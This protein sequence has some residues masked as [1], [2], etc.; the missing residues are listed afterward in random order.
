VNSS[1]TISH[2]S[3]KI[4]RSIILPGSKSESN[5]TLII[6]KLSGNKIY[7]NNL[8]VADDTQILIRLLSDK[9]KK[10]DVKDAGTDMRFLIAC[11]C[12]LNK[13]K[14]ITGSPR[15]QERPVEKLIDALHDI[16][17]K[18]QYLKNR[19]FPPVEIIPVENLHLTNE[20]S[21]DAGESS[22]FISALLM[23]APLLPEGL[24]IKLKN[25][26]VSKPYIEMTLQMM[27]LCGVNYEWKKNII[28]IKKQAYRK[29]EL[30]IETDWSA[31][32]YWYSIAALADEAKIELR[33]LKKNSMQG[34]SIIAE[35]MKKFGVKT[36]YFSKGIRIKKE[37]IPDV[38]KMSFNFTDHPDL[39]QTILVLASIKN[40]SLS[41]SGLE[42]LKIKETNR[43]EALQNELKKIG[44]V[45]IKKK[46]NVYKLKPDFKS[47][48]QKIETY[49]DHRM[50]MAFAPL[51]LINKINIVNPSVVSKSYPNFWEDLKQAGFILKNHS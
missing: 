1:L 23:I 7:I 11:F 26:I 39:A 16:G 35:W 2:L 44:A 22:Q 25:K 31:A 30:K 49:N 24:T 43:I 14:I 9:S 29:T 38:K 6:N 47:P 48:S 17:F 8:S 41:V 33:G 42:T 15:M 34:D 20:V 28:K 19:G 5:R 3:G 13:N 40:I 21:V 27:N 12:A 36:E 10:L 46:K 45:L 37:K 32:S 50:A 51:A 18:I 4:S